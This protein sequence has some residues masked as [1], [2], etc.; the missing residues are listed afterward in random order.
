MTA[1]NAGLLLSGATCFSNTIAPTGIDLGSANS[2]PSVHTWG[3]WLN[4]GLRYRTRSPPAETARVDL[5]VAHVSYRVASLLQPY[6][7][8]AI[9]SHAQISTQLLITPPIARAE[10]R[11]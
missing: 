11:R 6:V 7:E 9:P 1:P 8:R 4:L 10:H 3:P 5:Q 2:R